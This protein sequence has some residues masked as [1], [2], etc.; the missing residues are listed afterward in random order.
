MNYSIV[1]YILS[2]AMRDKLVLSL[3]VSSVLVVS[4]SFFL[5]SA[6]IIEQD[7]FALVYMAGTLRLLLVFGLC[8]FVTFFIRRSFDNKDIEYMLS[9]PLGRKCFIVSYVFGLILL[10]LFFA[11]LAGLI[12]TMVGGAYF[13]S[14]YILWSYSLFIELVVMSVAAMFFAMA[15]SS[16]VSAVLVTFA[17]YILS[18]L[19]GELLGIASD[20]YDGASFELMSNAIKAV[21]TIVPRFDL[22][23]QSSWLLYGSSGDVGY[24]LITTQGVMF[25]TILSGAAMIDLVRRQF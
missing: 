3:V 9:R 5:G 2:A 18:R 24:A 15:L 4:L 25:V 20:F 19:I 7:Q 10:S 14:A 23:T 11:V 17:F 12:V 1:K 22:L 13:G 16:P 6:A 8:L 21:S